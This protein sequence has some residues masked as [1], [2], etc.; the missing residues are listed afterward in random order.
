MKKLFIAL[1]V[2]VATSAFA[3]SAPNGYDWREWGPD[4]RLMFVVG[5]YTALA[6]EVPVSA[7]NM[8]LFLDHV[9][10][11]RNYRIVPVYDVIIMVLENA[12]DS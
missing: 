1:L 2:L 10:S 9:Y 5:F 12:E 8:V 4:H 3:Q 6:E 11:D 7:G